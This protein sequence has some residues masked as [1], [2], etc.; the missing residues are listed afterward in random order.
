MLYAGLLK[1][2]LRTTAENASSSAP[3]PSAAGRTPPPRLWFDATFDASPDSVKDA[4]RALMR[5]PCGAGFR[6]RYTTLLDPEMPFRADPLALLVQTRLHNV[7]FC[8]GCGATL[9]YHSK[10]FQGLGSRYHSHVCGLD[11]AVR[12]GKPFLNLDGGWVFANATVCPALNDQCYFQPITACPLTMCTDAACKGPRRHAG[13]GGIGERPRCTGDA[14]AAASCLCG[15]QCD[16]EPLRGRKHSCDNLTD[17]PVG[18][19]GVTG[20]AAALQR[21]HLWWTGQLVF[22]LLQPGPRLQAVLAQDMADPFFAGQRGQTVNVHVRRKPQE[23]SQLFGLGEYVATARKAFG[24][25]ASRFLMQSNDEADVA[26]AV[27]GTVRG[28]GGIVWGWTRFV[29]TG[30]DLQVHNDPTKYTR[31]KRQGKDLSVDTES[32]TVHSL[33]NLFYATRSRNWIC[34]YSSNWCRLAL[35]LAYA[36]YGVAPRV[37][38]LDGWSYDPYGWYSNEAVERAIN[39]SRRGGV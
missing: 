24:R 7:Q 18:H 4:V 20:G 19:L 17:I 21:P 25:V 3:S 10:L 29:R 27:R 38:S 36:T 12:R 28:A 15:A 26:A 22:F 13:L 14:A 39:E 37:H 32:W 9:V 2:R 16:H 1:D 34:T 5:R 11:N 35:R 31:R 30:M 23:M 6:A 33:R 8:S